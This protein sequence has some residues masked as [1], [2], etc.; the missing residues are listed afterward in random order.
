MS[1]LGATKLLTC[2]GLPQVMGLHCFL[3]NCTTS[4]P[5]REEFSS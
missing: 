1:V 4:H 5:T 3:S 2:P